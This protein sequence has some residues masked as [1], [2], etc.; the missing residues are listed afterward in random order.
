ME[1]R[2]LRGMN[3]EALDG[4]GVDGAGGDPPFFCVLLP[5]F[6]LLFFVFLRFPS[7]L[8]FLFFF[9]SSLS[10]NLRAKPASYWKNEEFHPNRFCTNPV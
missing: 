5:F 10:P 3:W 9:V 1:G 2:R 7:F 8:C 4:F 6:V